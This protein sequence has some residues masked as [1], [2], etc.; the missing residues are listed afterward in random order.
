M[1]PIIY[2]NISIVSSCRQ[3]TPKQTVFLLR[4]PV[5]RVRKISCFRSTHRDIHRCGIE[6]AL[7]YK[8]FSPGWKWYGDLYDVYS[9]TRHVTWQHHGTR[10]G[11]SSE[12]RIDLCG[13]KRKQGGHAVETVEIIH[14]AMEYVNDQLKANAKWSSLQRHDVILPVVQKLWDSCMVSLNWVPTIESALWGY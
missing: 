4:W 11:C 9:G 5:L 3:G 1:K 8:G 14:N 13:S 6:C 7:G 10:P 2:L 12:G